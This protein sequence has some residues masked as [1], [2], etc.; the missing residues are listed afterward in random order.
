MKNGVRDGEY[1]VYKN[2][3][4]WIRGCWSELEEDEQRIIENSDNDIWMVITINGKRVY[5]GEFDEKKNRS[6]Y[7]CV[8]EDDQIKYSGLFK[9]DQLVHI[10]Q[11]FID[12]QQ[13]IEYVGDDNNLLVLNRRPIYMG[14]YDYDSNTNRFLRHGIGYRFYEHSGICSYQSLWNHG[15]EDIDHQRLFHNGWSRDYSQDKFIRDVV[16]NDPEPILIGNEPFILSPLTIEELVTEDNR[17]NDPTAT[18]LELTELPRLKRVS[19]GSSSLRS[20]RRFV[21]QGLP[22]LTEFVINP[23]CMRLTTENEIQPREDSECHFV[24]CPKLETIEMGETCFSDYVQLEVANLPNLQTLS[25]GRFAFYCSPVVCMRGELNGWF[26]LRSSS[27][28]NT[29]L[30]FLFLFVLSR[31]CIG[32]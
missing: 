21:V 31:H 6:G 28:S 13:M 14:G 16:F 29:P 17:F 1:T 25:I 26:F 2:G 5:K 3:I 15:E 4:V 32:E 9:E 22:E 23:H 19:I 12:Q 10:H 20:I 11:Q 24:D 27:T 18:Q 30:Q 7:G 8:Y